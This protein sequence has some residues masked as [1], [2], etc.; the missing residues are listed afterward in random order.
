M[1]NIKYL[2]NIQF[3]Q[4]QLFSDRIPQIKFTFISQIFTNLNFDRKNKVK[5]KAFKIVIVE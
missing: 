5:Y 4:A 3:F 2:F 1:I